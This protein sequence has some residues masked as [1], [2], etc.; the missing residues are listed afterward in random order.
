MEPTPGKVPVSENLH[1]EILTESIVTGIIKVSNRVWDYLYYD[2]VIDTPEFQVTLSRLPDLY[3][4]SAHAVRTPDLKKIENFMTQRGK[5]PAIYTDPLTPTSLVNELFNQGYIRHDSGEHNET[6]LWRILNLKGPTQDPSS[7]LKVPESDLTLHYLTPQDNLQLADFL[8]I[9]GTTNQLDEQT[10]NQIRHNFLTKS[11]PDTLVY[12]IVAYLKGQPVASMCL[13]ISE[14]IAHISESGTQESYRG[15]GIFPWMRLK[16]I[17]KAHSARCDF[18]VSN[19][20]E[21]NS[22]SQRGS[23]KSGFLKGFYRHLWVKN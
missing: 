22:S 9:D 3:L 4:N 10:V 5:I 1:S 20:L 15:L 2:E 18:L 17:E 12:P 13:G 11:R 23:D 14:G 19:T 6:E 16:M 8:I 21:S 7:V